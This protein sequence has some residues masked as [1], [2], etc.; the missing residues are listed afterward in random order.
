MRSARWPT[1]NGRGSGGDERAEKRPPGRAALLK[2]SWSGKRDSNPRHQPWQ[3][4]TLPTELF[5]LTSTASANFSQRP[6]HCQATSATLQR[7]LTEGA[8]S[9][10]LR[11]AEREGR[12][13]RVVKWL[14]CRVVKGSRDGAGRWR[15]YAA[16]TEG[17]Q[18]R[19]DSGWTGRP[20]THST[21]Q[22]LDLLLPMKVLLDVEVT[23][24][25]D[26]RPAVRAGVWVRRVE[27]FGDE[28]RH[29]LSAERAV[30]LDGGLTG[31]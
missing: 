17:I 8:W 14:S 24:V 26:D 11:R 18:R 2:I 13:G 29:L 19:K 30:D 5:P 4:C 23:D 7:Q 31:E 10:F 15:R 16:E 21:T 6:G 1:R 3:G 9:V 25:D 28:A 27:Q 20:S 22:P 12:G